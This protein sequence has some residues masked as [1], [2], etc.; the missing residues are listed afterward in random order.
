MKKLFT[1]CATAAM[2]LTLSAQSDISEGSMFVYTS[3]ATQFVKS[4]PYD[5]DINFGYAI[6]D[7]IV[8]H[9]G[10]D[11]NEGLGEETSFNLG[12]R[13][14]WKGLFFQAT[15]GDA[16]QNLMQLVGTGTY[17]QVET[18]TYEQVG[19][20]TY[21][22]VWDGTYEQVWDGT[23]Q[24]DGMGNQVLDKNGNP[25]PTDNTIDALD[26]NGN[27]IPTDNTIDGD[28]IMM[29]GDEIMTDGDEIMVEEAIGRNFTAGF[30]Y[31]MMLDNVFDSGIMSDMYIE[32]YMGV[33]SSASE[34]NVTFSTALRLGY[35]F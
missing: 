10:I 11:Q 13:Y 6:Q 8:L 29:D 18:G 1:L 34:D 7:N 12:A 22:Q 30:G 19:T 2:A 21:E 14:F 5:L 15:V 23:Y 32:P 16:M 27:P 25:I 26:D 28:E 35:R 3:D 4:N 17:V 20:G 24:E 33:F 9:V 31:M